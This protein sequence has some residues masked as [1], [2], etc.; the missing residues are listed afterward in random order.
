MK[1]GDTVSEKYTGIQLKILVLDIKTAKCE[2]VDEK[3]KE[4]NDRAHAFIPK[5]GVFKVANL[6]ENIN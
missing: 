5:V 1:V 3:F 6:V 2:Y 4:W